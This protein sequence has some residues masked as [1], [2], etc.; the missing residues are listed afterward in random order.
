MSSRDGTY[1]ELV[2]DRRAVII[3]SK[4]QRPLTLHGIGEDVD[5]HGA[6]IIR[7]NS[8]AQETGGATHAQAVSDRKKILTLVSLQEGSIAQSARCTRW[9]QYLA[10][11]DCV[12]R[13]IA[14]V[15]NVMADFLSRAVE[16]IE[17]G[18]VTY[19]AAIFQTVS[20]NNIKFCAISEYSSHMTIRGTHGV[21]PQ[22]SR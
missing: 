15:R 18:T 20:R 16:P 6:G 13:H 14:G 5:H 11:F 19:L 21:P 9:R 17:A 7:Y 1:L 8:H 12:I 3:R 22:K 4:V 10:Q 2:E